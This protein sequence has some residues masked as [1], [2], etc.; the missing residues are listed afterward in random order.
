LNHKISALALGL[1]CAA[2]AAAQALPP[3]IAQPQGKL[4]L[5]IPGIY[6]PEGLTLENPD[7]H[8]HFTSSFQSNFA[9]FNAAMARQLTSLPI[10]SPASGFTYT[11][12][13]SLGVYTRSAKS[14]GPILAERAET[15]GKDKFLFGFSYQHFTFTS[16]DGVNLRDV[17]VVY[18]HGPTT[19]TEF[20]KDIITTNNFID[21]QVGQTTGFLS[22]GLTN[23]VDLAVA[24]PILSVSL[25]ATSHAVIQ[26]IGTGND[27]TI[28][29]FGTPNGGL[30]KTFSSAGS[31]SGVGDTVARVKAT[32]LKWRG[33]GVAGILDVRLPTGDEYN[34]LGSGAVGVRG[35]MA[36]SGQVGPISPHVNFGYQWN[37]KSVLAGD[38]ALGVKASLPGSIVYAVGAD[39]GLTPRMTVA[40]DVFGER[41][42]ASRVLSTAFVAA[43]NVSYRAIGFEKLGYSVMSGSL[44]LKINAGGRFVVTVNSLFRLN[45]TGLR[46]K[47]VPLVGLSYTL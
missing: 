29:T 33:G 3:S 16:I 15:I 4:A 36:A 30:E 34:F 39:A 14:L 2:T 35:F 5:L 43:N 6:G 38:V 19:N 37:G 10:P 1:L 8:A 46:S 25:A 17:P 9:P 47:V 21:P 7:H 41:V 27:A 42:T 44:G 22:Y 31:A 20:I 32:A 23:R 13:G 40:A 12:E 24:V 45:H 18:R 26:R 28:H 11:F